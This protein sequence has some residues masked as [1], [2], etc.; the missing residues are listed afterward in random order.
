MTYKKG[1]GD[2]LGVISLNVEIIIDRT[3]LDP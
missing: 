1:E 3:L 2:P